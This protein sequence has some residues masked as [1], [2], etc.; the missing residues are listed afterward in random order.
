MNRTNIEKQI[1]DSNKL[2]G[3]SYFTSILQEAYTYGLLND[4]DI[5]NI[6]LQCIEFLAYKS[7]RYNGGDSSSIRVET[8][9]SIMK[10]NLYTMGLFLKTFPDADYAVSKLKTTMV[11]ELYKKGRE[12]IKEKVHITENIYKIAKSNK[13]I[14][15]NYT[16]NVTLSDKGVGIFFRLYSPDYAAHE[17]PASIDY[18]LCNP[19]T[20]LT[21]IEFIQK[22]LENLFLENE[23]CNY[24]EP[25]V[26][27]HLLYG[28]DNG[29][30]D[31]LINIFEQVI[32]AA[33]GCALSNR[34]VKKLDISKEEIQ[35]LNSELT[36][37]DDY[38]IAL[39]IYKANEKILQEL[40]ITSTPLQR[41]IA[42]SLPRITSNIVQ[43]VKTNTLDKTFILP[44]NPDLT[45]KIEFL[46][47]VKMDDEDY[48]KLIDELLICRYSSDKL[49][50]IKEK[51]KSF[52][53]IEH[54][55]FDAMLNEGEVTSVLGVLGNTEIA[56]LIK[57]HP[58]KS[59]IQAVDLSES[60]QALRSYLENY[61]N[62]L[63]PERQEQIFEIVI[64]LIDG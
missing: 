30:H 61:I 37:H 59:D 34:S 32:T 35:L 21:G 57:K 38:A 33:L 1:I 39:T 11:P 47:D 58:Y 62:Q 25:R 51:V 2:S 27:H 3:E 40:N 36:R 28:Y 63:P 22:Y 60:E 31:L 26:M 24:F 8:A 29:Y 45:P 43:A 49:E 55:L 18:Q 41:Y 7:R 13:I 5:E 12:L 14:T 54:V 56:V 16:Y 17:I 23:F 19:V 50:L 42:M 48:R 64:H 52:G 10:S 46:S 53:D 4:F 9:E 15:S 6:Q 20:D 44:I